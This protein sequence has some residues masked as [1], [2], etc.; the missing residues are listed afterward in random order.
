MTARG[1]VTGK[2]GR[3]VSGTGEEQRAHHG[4]G[5]CAVRWEVGQM[6]LVGQIREFSPNAGIYSFSF[7]FCFP[8]LFLIHLNSNLNLFADELHI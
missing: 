1:R 3:P 6:K 8:I 4:V 5:P 2:W 7:I